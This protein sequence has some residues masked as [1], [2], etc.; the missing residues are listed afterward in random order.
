MKNKSI[1]IIF[2]L[3]YIVVATSATLLAQTSNV[4]QCA[5]YEPETVTLKG[6]LIR[7]AVINA[8]DRKETIWVL[9]LNNEICVSAD[10]NNDINSAY[11]EVKEVQLVFNNAQLAKFR[12][13]QNQ[14][15][16][17]T[18]T[19][20]AGHTQYHFTEVLLIVSRVKNK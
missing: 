12:L 16:S 13:L 7:K 18:G 20:F 5:A 19:L 4:K 15:L 2:S 14:N 10:S 8:S 17:V 3:I 1:K 9:K 11:D 6:K